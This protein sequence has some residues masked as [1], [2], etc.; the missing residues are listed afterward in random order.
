MSREVILPTVNRRQALI[1]SESYKFAVR[2]G[3]VLLLCAV[4]FAF[5]TQAVRAENVIPVKPSETV[6]I[7]PPAPRVR[8]LRAT[9]G[10]VC[11]AQI[12]SGATFSSTDSTAVQQAVDA[13]V[14]NDLVKV[15][16]T[17][18]GTQLRND[19]SQVYNQVVFISNT[20]TLQGGYQT[21]NWIV[22]DPVFNPTTLDALG[23]GRV[24]YIQTGHTV[25][26]SAL[27]L[28]NGA[29]DLANCKPDCVGAGVFVPFNSNVVIDTIIA[30]NNNAGFGGGVGNMGLVTVTNSV[31]ISN[32]ALQVGGGLYNF[33][34]ML[35]STSVLTG[36]QAGAGGAGLGNQGVLTVTDTTISDN[37][38]FK[39][40]GGG[41]LLGTGGAIQ[42]T[43][44]DFQTNDSVAAI[45]NTTIAANHANG[46]ND[47]GGGGIMVFFGTVN[48]LNSTLSGNTT[49]SKDFMA[50]SG[51]G[52]GGI[53]KQTNATT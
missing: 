44:D 29:I 45:I 6:Y 5:I 4:L 32:S 28:S 13:A 17:C 41:G 40:D 20:L 30:S 33:E 53:G 27:T 16:G 36:N 51:L 50:Y 25:T 35:L 12:G 39:V 48:L 3:A 19:N 15:A 38:S 1:H 9:T 49:S 46:A 43:K 52:A 7:A 2:G 23:A 8:Q 24:I 21:W 18:T 26:V 22:S 42:N 47:K 11:F 10:E 14:A 31:F 34:T 37:T